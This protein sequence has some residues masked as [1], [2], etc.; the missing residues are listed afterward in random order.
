MKVS[1][2]PEEPEDGSALDGF[3]QIQ[4]PSDCFNTFQ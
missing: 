2:S 4:A 3:E 1:K